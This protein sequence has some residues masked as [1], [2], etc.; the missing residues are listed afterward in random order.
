MRAARARR[1]SRPLHAESGRA[2]GPFR[3]VNCA[4]FTPALLE[5]ELF[6]HTRRAFTGAVK[7]RPG[8]FSLADRGTLFLDEV[9]DIPL[10][11]Q[12]KLLRVLQEKVFVPLAP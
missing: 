5:S 2:A 12:G 3:A 1:W 6:G 4:A 9:T 7:D 8:P 11:L 10:D